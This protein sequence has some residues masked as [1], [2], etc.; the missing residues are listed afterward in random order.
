MQGIL[1]GENARSLVLENGPACWALPNNNND[2]NKST[3]PSNNNRAAYGGGER[4]TDTQSRRRGA[5]F[6]SATRSRAVAKA[7]GALPNEQALC[8][9]HLKQELHKSQAQEKLY[10]SIALDCFR[11][12]N[13]MQIQL[14]RRLEH[15]A[16]LAQ[17]RDNLGPAE[18][19]RRSRITALK[20]RLT[21]LISSQVITAITEQ[22]ADQG[23]G[24]VVLHDKTTD[25]VEEPLLRQQIV[26]LERE[27]ASLTIQRIYRGLVGRNA[28]R[29]RRREH[30][31]SI[32]Q[33]SWRKYRRKWRME[34]A[35]TT[36]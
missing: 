14:R 25:S 15:D 32:V 22:K 31:A 16:K 18:I 10:R 17:K 19:M 24:E 6:D 9:E 1:F 35:S 7:V 29:Q 3:I 33:R 11:A 34:H 2:N 12:Q 20:R 27:L 26:E 5:Q 4:L 28:G 8:I 23:G 21:D 13:R 36:C 30:A